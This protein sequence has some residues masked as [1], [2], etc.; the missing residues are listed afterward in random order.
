LY[1]YYKPNKIFFEKEICELLDSL[2]LTVR[3]TLVEISTHP[4]DPDH[5]D[6]K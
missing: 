5:L 2:A 4:V 6:Y 1:A 3:D